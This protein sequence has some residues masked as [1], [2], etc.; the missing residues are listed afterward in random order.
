MVFQDIVVNIPAAL[1]LV[2]EGPAPVVLDHPVPEGQFQI[3]VLQAFQI[4][5]AH[6]EHPVCP[7]QHR[8]REHLANRDIYVCHAVFEFRFLL[9]VC[10]RMEVYP[11][12]RAVPALSGH[13]DI[14]SLIKGVDHGLLYFFVKLS[15]QRV[16]PDHFIK[17]LRVLLPNLR[18]RIGNDRE[19]PLFSSDIFICDLPGTAVILQRQLPLLLRIG[20]RFRH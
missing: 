11:D 3:P 6:M 16:N 8:R 18:H 15:V 2:R 19:T 9:R 20:R 1:L 4:D 14:F 13:M 12:I 7:F 10:Q 5:P 17:D